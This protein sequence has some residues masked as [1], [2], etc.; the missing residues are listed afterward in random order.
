[1]RG[2]QAIAGR[3]YL[4]SK[5]TIDV[6]ATSD[7]IHG[8]FEMTKRGEASFPEQLAKDLLAAGLVVLASDTSENKAA[9]T[10]ANKIPPAARS[11]SGKAG[12]APSSAPVSASE[13]AEHTGASADVCTD[14][15]GVLAADA[16]TSVQLPPDVASGGSDASV[17]VGVGP[18]SLAAVAAAN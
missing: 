6:I 12:K 5:M 13:A 10:V 15:P 1:M 17:E 7:F 16:A 8:K 18:V 2:R 11:K 9:P 3:F 14:K 4:E